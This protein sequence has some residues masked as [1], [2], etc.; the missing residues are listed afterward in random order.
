M[1]NE[2][3]QTDGLLFYKPEKMHYNKPFQSIEQ[4]IALLAQRGLIIDGYTS[5][6]L[7]HLNGSSPNSGALYS[8]T[9]HSNS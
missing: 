1:L 2:H 7:Q 9:Q 8:S 3:P 5:Q 6:Y 4:Q